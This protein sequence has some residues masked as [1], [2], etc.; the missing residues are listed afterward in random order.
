M[1][2]QNKTASLFVVA[3]LV[4]LSSY[5]PQSV[6]TSVTRATLTQSPGV[7]TPKHVLEPLDR[8]TGAPRSTH[9][10]E[11]IDTRIRIRDGMA[12]VY[13]PEGQFEMGSNIAGRVCHP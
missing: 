5:A 1:K 9:G 10:I 8:P 4:I 2:G 6:P 7:P 13:V 12:L 11:S 3:L